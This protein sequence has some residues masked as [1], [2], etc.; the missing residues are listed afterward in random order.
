[1][2]DSIMKYICQI[3]EKLCNSEYKIMIFK[4]FNS[5]NM[6][7]SSMRFRTHDLVHKPSCGVVS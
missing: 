5:V 2:I 3:G 6:K 7:K 4:K 1:M